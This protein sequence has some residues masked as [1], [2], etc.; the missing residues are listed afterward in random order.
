M[1][2]GG[3]NIENRNLK[4]FSI[5]TST[6]FS[7]PEIATILNKTICHIICDHIFLSNLIENK[8]QEISTCPDRN[9]TTESAQR[10]S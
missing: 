9:A 1:C 8:L 3:E 4:N 10:I 2:F 5:I 7:S 6:V